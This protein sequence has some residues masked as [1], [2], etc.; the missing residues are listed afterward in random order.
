M[1]RSGP[2]PRARQTGAEGRLCVETSWPG[3]TPGQRRLPPVGAMPASLEHLQV[4]QR[5]KGSF[6]PLWCCS[7]VVAKVSAYI[8]IRVT[9]TLQRY[10]HMRAHLAIPM[11]AC[12]VLYPVQPPSRGYRAAKRSFLSAESPASGIKSQTIK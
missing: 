11:C 9:T 12:V 10:F 1:T 8:H 3:C 4:L 6:C 5:A 7:R 2:P